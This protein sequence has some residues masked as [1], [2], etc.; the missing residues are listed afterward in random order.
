LKSK[1]AEVPATIAQT[2]ELDLEQG[3]VDGEKAVIV[4]DATNEKNVESLGEKADLPTEEVQDANV[5]VLI[6]EDKPAPAQTEVDSETA[7]SE[8]QEVMNIETGDP[9]VIQLRN[10]NDQYTGL[11]N[12]AK[13][14]IKEEGWGP[15]YRMWF[16][17]FC[18]LLSRLL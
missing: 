4:F 16:I 17:T 1:P 15:L 5:E 8:L 10:E 12:C 11:F 3:V 7:D 14:I 9:V 2:E 18:G 6:S 13:T